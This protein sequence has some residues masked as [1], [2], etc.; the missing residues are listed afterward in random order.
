M[1]SFISEKKNL[2]YCN[3]ETHAIIW[4]KNYFEILFHW[5][6]IRKT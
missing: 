2:E 3:L 4:Q 6:I 1:Q 5:F